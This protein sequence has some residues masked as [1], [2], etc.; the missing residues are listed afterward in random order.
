MRKILFI[1]AFCCISLTLLAQGGDRQIRQKIS[2]EASAIKTMQCDFVQTKHMKMLNNEMVSKGKM[3]YQQP[4]CLRWEYTTPYTYTFIFNHDKV[5]LKNARRNDVIDV[6]QNKLF[7]EIAHIMLNSV[8]GKSLTD[9]KN[10]R[11]EI[12]TVGG[13]WVAT[14]LPQSREMK[15]MFSR[16]VLHISHKLAVVTHVELIEKRGDKTI[17]DLNNIKT[18][19]TLSADMFAV[20]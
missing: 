1:M 14:L 9:D 2:Q 15:Q 16:I 4:S 7:R 12:S 3:Y 6:N 18:N 5:L 17:I 13:E 11:S 10:F 8:V 19:E 20:R